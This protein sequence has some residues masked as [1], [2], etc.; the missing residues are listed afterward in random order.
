M[1]NAPQSHA[2]RKKL[3]ARLE[4]LTEEEIHLILR[5]ES[6]NELCALN[7]LASRELQYIIQ[8]E[9]RRTDD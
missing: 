2:A 3:V 4:K 7:G 6:T 9:I 5:N 8:R 1:S